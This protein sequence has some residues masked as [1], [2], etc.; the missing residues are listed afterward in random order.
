MNNLILNYVTKSNTTGRA[1]LLIHSIDTTI[2]H[3]GKIKM[4]QASPLQKCALSLNIC[5]LFAF[6]DCR[7]N[8]YKYLTLTFCRRILITLVMMLTVINCLA[9]IIND[10]V[11]FQLFWDI[12]SIIVRNN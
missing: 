6:L 9:S 11:F 8:I 1:T 2:R 3:F 4:C 12:E 5:H 10:Y 7:N